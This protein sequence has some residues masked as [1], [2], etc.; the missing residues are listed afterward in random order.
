K[1]LFLRLRF[2]FFK[3]QF[4]KHLHFQLSTFNFQFFPHPGKMDAGSSLTAC[5]GRRLLPA[6]LCSPAA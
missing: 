3:W 2:P 5:Q 4:E 1:S 6:A